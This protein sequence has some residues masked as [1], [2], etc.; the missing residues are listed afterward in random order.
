HKIFHHEFQSIAGWT[1]FLDRE[2]NQGVA[3]LL[4]SPYLQGW[5]VRSF[6][7]LYIACWIHH[8]VEKG[9]YMIN[10]GG[11][12]PAHRDR[13]NQA[14]VRNC[15][16]RLSS[17][18]SKSGYSA[19]K[20][21]SFLKGYRELLVQVEWS[22]GCHLFL[23]SEG[24]LALDPRH[25]FSFAN[26]DET[27]EGLTCSK[28]L[29]DFAKID[30]GLVD[31]RAAENFSPVYK[32]LVEGLG[33]KH[34]KALVPI[35]SVMKALFEQTGYIGRVPGGSS[36]FDVASLE[37]LGFA[38]QSYCG[39]AYDRSFQHAAVTPA[40]VAELRRL[41]TSLLTQGGA[42]R[43]QIFQEI[44]VRPEEVDRSLQNFRRLAAL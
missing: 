7:A 25:W 17:H 8:P 19:A 12:N 1:R 23:K 26:K 42:K 20:G 13:I 31:R 16:G 36:F 32:E 9:S 43:E 28:A 2:L 44:R 35:R 40:V 14:V 27:G 11:L 15:V 39:S 33:F 29:R 38:L 3:H 30:N 18:L 5:S 41:A 34:H 10:L 37:Q 21:W 6:Q 4:N 24:Y 22:G